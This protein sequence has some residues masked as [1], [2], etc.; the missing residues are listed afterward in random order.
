M[1]CYSINENPDQLV[2]GTLLI[3]IA[4]RLKLR[5][6]LNPLQK[7]HSCPASVQPP[8]WPVL[9]SAT[10]TQS[11]RDHSYLN[12][13][14]NRPH[15]QSTLTLQAAKL[16]DHPRQLFELVESLLLHHSTTPR[17]DESAPHRR[18]LQAKKTSSRLQ[19]TQS[20]CPPSPLPRGTSSP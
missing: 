11:V 1:E 12:Q 20:P 13:L 3:G 17:R 14:L 18:N 5:R 2:T 10:A 8:P 16:L 6:L 19:L 4:G 15:L 7:P 9:T